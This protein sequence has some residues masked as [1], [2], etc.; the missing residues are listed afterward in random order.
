MRKR[1]FIASIMLPMGFVAASFTLKAADH[2]SA[3][4]D[5]EQVSKLLS[6]AKTIAFELKEDAMTMASFPRMTLSFESHAVAINQIR[7]HLDALQLQAAKLQDVKGF[8]APWQKTA[9]DRMAPFLDEL[10]GYTAAVIERI[11]DKPKFLNTPE[12]KD[13]LE[14]NA[15]YAEDLANMIGQFVDYGRAK[16]RLQTLTEKL[17][18][19]TH[20]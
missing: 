18:L 3:I 7:E 1:A 20:R 9:I 8:A 16:D 13:Y 15:D 6:E 19:Q 2:T 5:S 12:Y 14:A 17:E 11:N 10:E 4:T